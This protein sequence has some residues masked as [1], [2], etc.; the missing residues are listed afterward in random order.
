MKILI[1]EDDFV[2]ANALKKELS[3][4]EYEVVLAKDFLHILE[5]VKKEQPQLIL[6]D[7]NLPYHNGYYWC[8]QIRAF[9]EVPLIFISSVNEKM[10]ILMAMQM[11]GDDFIRKPIDLQ[12]TVSKIQ[13]LLRRT[14]S[15]SM[16]EETVE[17]FQQ[18]QLNVGKSTL[19]YHDQSITLTYTELQ[20]MRYLFQ[21][22][23]DYAKREDILDYCWQN[24]QF[25]DDNTL[26]VNMTRIRRKLKSIGLTSFIQTKKNLG[27][28]IT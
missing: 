24:N 17:H 7:I 2:I 23:G 8:S 26:A 19:N 11:G 21:Q 10:D 15:F 14:Y 6:L 5:I 20:I 18:V 22:Q 25:I 27:Y 13:A 1:I 28:C 12:L 3:K 9:S 4:N 16:N